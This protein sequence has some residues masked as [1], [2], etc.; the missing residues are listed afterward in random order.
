[1]KKPLSPI[2]AIVLL[3][4]FVCFS[5]MATPNPVYNRVNVTDF[6][7]IP[8][9]G[10]PDTAAINFALTQG[11]SIY[12]P[13]G[14]YNYDGSM[15]MQGSLGGK[16][17][18][19]YGD[20]PGVSTIIFTNA[21]SG[22]I[23]APSLGVGNTLV[24]EGL[25]LQAGSNCGTAIDATF[26]SVGFFKSATIHNVQ[27]RGSANDGDTGT[28]WTGG[29]HLV[30]AHHSVLDKVEINGKKNTTTNGIWFDQSS[31]GFSTGFNMSNLQ[32]KWCNTAFRT[33]G[34]VEG[35]YLTGFEFT[36]CGRGGSPAVDLN[37]TEPLNGGAFH[38]VNGTIDMVG[39]GLWLTNP[40]FVKVSNVRFKHNGPDAT[41]GGHMVYINGG[42]NVTVSQCSFYGP[43]ANSGV[44]WENA[45]F[46]INSASLQFNGN[47]FYNLK[48]AS[49]YGIV[50][51]GNSP[52]LRITDNLFDAYQ[53]QYWIS[54]TGTPAPYYC[55]NSPSA[56]G[57]CG[58]NP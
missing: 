54:V 34:H 45:I 10:N 33:T 46:A 19:F 21:T 4:L 29:I 9:D 12:F 31:G 48:A 38:L 15:I 24:I 52:S 49:D 14:T 51:W 13:P 44:P 17:W 37:I 41:D 8:N 35:V 57:V 27:I 55:G 40:G 1:M 26:S 43:D 47:N 16:S 22:G 56:S 3:S 36:S 20:G 42:F 30:G 50:V 39:S 23:N 5:A 58:N 28:N 18:R 32:V 11:Q 53:T 25:T 6:G 7:A 2:I